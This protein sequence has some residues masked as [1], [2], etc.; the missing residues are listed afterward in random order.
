MKI[1]LSLVK[2]VVLLLI[3]TILLSGCNN[4]GAKNYKRGMDAFTGE[5]YE[6]AA[7]E[8]SKAIEERPQASD[9]YVAYG[10]TLLM[11]EDYQEAINIYNQVILDKDS[12]VVLEN[13]KKAYYGKGVA[14]F[15]SLQYK[16]ALEQFNLALSIN[17]LEKWNMDILLYKGEAE[18][19]ERLYEEAKQT[20]SRLIEMEPNNGNFFLKRATVYQTLLDYDNSLAD[21]E[22]A[23]SLESNYDSNFGKYFILKEQ[24]KEEEASDLLEQL[25]NIKITTPMDQFMNAKVFYYMEE[26]DKAIAGFEKSIQEGILEGNYYI[27]MIKEEEED[28]ENAIS[29]YIEYITTSSYNNNLALVYNQLGFSYLQ[30]LE[31]EKALECFN[32]GLNLK[33]SLIESKLMRNK[34]I[35]LEFLGEYTQANDLL[36]TYIKSYPEDEEGLRELEFVKTRLPETSNLE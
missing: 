1:N 23:I 21:Y 16:K 34:I 33:D 24:G 30:I 5:D 11:L 12:K 18:T 32:T 31:Y 22:K 25:A 3:I 20:Y 7:I 29:Y 15:K 35:A 2:K 8:F 17:E 28:Y 9:Y 19:Y 10:H 6:T 27:G 14:Y 36:E 4:K 26:Y 13:N